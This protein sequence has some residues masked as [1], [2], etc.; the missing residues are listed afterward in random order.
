MTPADLRRELAKLFH[1]LGHTLS[2]LPDD[3]DAPAPRAPRRP[4]RSHDITPTELSAARAR[5]ALRRAG[6]RS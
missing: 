2:N 4:K 6:V 1:L 5:R 3:G